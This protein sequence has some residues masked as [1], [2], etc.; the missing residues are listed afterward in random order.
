MDWHLCI[1]STISC[2]STDDAVKSAAATYIL[3]HNR[4][5][6]EASIRHAQTHLQAHS[7]TCTKNGAELHMLPNARLV[8]LPTTPRHL[9][10]PSKPAA[11]TG[12]CLSKQLVSCM[13]IPES[14][15]SPC[16]AMSWHRGVFTHQCQLGASCAPCHSWKA[17]ACIWQCNSNLYNAWHAS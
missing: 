13:H 1:F 17:L 4:L 15:A 7:L 14:P 3:G 12:F 2:F 6:Q 8:L 10:G 9:P 5:P 16:M 11:Q